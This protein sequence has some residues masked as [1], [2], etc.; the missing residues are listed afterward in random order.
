MLLLIFAMYFY[1]KLYV[2]KI[3]K[4]SGMYRYPIYFYHAKS[5]SKLPTFTFMTEK[6]TYISYLRVI[7]TVFVI[8]IHA[9]TG[10]LYDFNNFSFDWQY[11]NWINSATRCAVPLF[12]VIT[13][14]LLLPRQENILHSYKKRI[15]KLLY[16]FLFWTIVYIIY[17]LIR[18]GVWSIWPQHQILEFAKNKLIHGANAHL[19]YL[20]MIIGL[21]FA[22]PYLSRL[23]SQLSFRDIEIF[24]LLWF[25]SMIVLNKRFTDEIPN[26]DLTF[27]S[28]YAGYLVLGYYLNKK[29]FSF[30]QWIM[31]IALIALTVITALM[32][33]YLTANNNKLDTLAY[34][35]VFPTTALMAAALF[36]L[37]KN[38]VGNKKQLPKYIAL[39]DNYSFGIYLVHIIPLNY[40]HPIISK[41]V[42][43][44]WVVPLATGSTLILSIG[45]IYLL[46]KI[47]YGK[48]VS[49]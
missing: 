14:A 48:Y 24:L 4:K 18:S 26:I 9:S 47:P 17:I 27:F 39:I 12:V 38:R 3:L 45:I 42:S 19:W 41:Y 2:L 15:P 46:R 49:G 13:G 10:F 32:T 11:A 8:L 37:I 28:G 5:Y 1:F 22:V 7:A 33:Q 25:V 6:N 31:V 21:S 36:I 44:L 34:N 16:P 43:T 30:P 20:Y 23:V 29:N 40:V 35:Y